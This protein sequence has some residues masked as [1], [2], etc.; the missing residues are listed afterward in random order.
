M[1]HPFIFDDDAS[2]SVEEDRGRRLAGSRLAV[3]QNDF[4]TVA[5]GHG[6]LKALELPQ[7]VCEGGGAD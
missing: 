3:E 5:Q 6:F 2:R 7:D 1:V 4:T